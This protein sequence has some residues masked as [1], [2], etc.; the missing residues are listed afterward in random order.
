VRHRVHLFVIALA[1]SSPEVGA[2]PTPA[3]TAEATRL[4]EEGRDLAQ[5]GDYAHACEKFTRSLALVPAPGTELNLADCQEHLNHFGEAWRLFDHVAVEAERAA[6]A[7]RAAFARGRA[8]A[9]AP[10]LATV[11]VRVEHPKLAGLS[12]TIAGHPVTPAAEVRVHVD[13]GVVDVVATAPGSPGFAKS[14]QGVAG[15]TL[16]VDVPALDLPIGRAEVPTERRHSRVVLAGMF[17]AV[18]LATAI[19]STVLI[20]KGRSDYNSAAD[21]PHCRRIDDNTRVICDPI[22]QTEIGHAQQ[23]ADISTGFAIGSGLLLGAAVYIYV[24]APRDAVKV[25]PTAGAN[26]VGVTISGVF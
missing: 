11:V 19:T 8:D 12:L 22:G 10:K 21:G 14:T 20:A 5:Q 13:A 9:L 26:G 24:T 25:T 7:D 15:A 4:F 3:S 6:N 18:G 17:G 23:L 1:L 2:A 16:E